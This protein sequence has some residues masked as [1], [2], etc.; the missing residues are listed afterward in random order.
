M[1]KIEKLEKRI[2][3]LEQKLAAKEETETWKALTEAVIVFPD[4]N[5]R[6]NLEQKYS[7][8]KG[9]KFER[10]D[11]KRAIENAPHPND[12]PPKKLEYW[13]KFQK[14]LKRTL[15]ENYGSPAW[16]ELCFL[17]EEAINIYKDAIV[18]YVLKEGKYVDLGGRKPEINREAVI[19]KWEKY[20]TDPEYI[21]TDTQYKGEPKKEIIYEQIAEDINEPTATRTI[22]DI[23]TAY[24][25]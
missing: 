22:R 5:Y 8:P 20:S 13:A 16:H 6:T 2:E 7:F 3:E 10:F 1:N 9:N 24:L 14:D 17:V 12:K 18:R 19:Q 23:I 25:K 11:L 21:H 15:G 4:G